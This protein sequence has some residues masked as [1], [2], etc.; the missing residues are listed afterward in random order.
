MRRDS[1]R[2]VLGPPVRAANLRARVSGRFSTASFPCMLILGL[3]TRTQDRWPSGWRRQ[4]ADYAAVAM[5]LAAVRAL[6]GAPSWPLWPGAVRHVQAK[7]KSALA[8]LLGTFP[9]PGCR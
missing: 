6:A 4:S 9:T 3:E 1:E 2:Q 7:A 8:C 5:N